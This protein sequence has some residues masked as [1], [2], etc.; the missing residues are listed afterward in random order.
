MGYLD[1]LDGILRGG[2]HGL[3]ESFAAAQAAWIECRELPD[4][5]FAGRRGGNADVYY[6]DFAL[7]ALDLVAGETPIFATTARHL[8]WTARSPADV[9]A[10][11]SLLSC[12]RTLRRHDLSVRCDRR[13]VERA[14]G[15]QALPGGA[16]GPPEV[17]SAS[18]YQTFLAVL[19]LQMLG[20]DAPSEETCA[21]MAAL[22]RDSGGFAER[23]DGDRA[24][25]NAT[26]A[27]VAVLLM[28]NA[29]AQIDLPA[30]A[31]FIIDRQA[32]DGGL[33]AHADATGGDLLS[34]F[35]GLLTL[36][37]IGAPSELDLPA[38][39]RFVRGAAH[40]GGG[41]GALPG[42]PQADVEYTF[43]GIATFGLLRSLVEGAG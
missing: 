32:P 14:I 33:C 22:Q 8:Q 19:C 20:Q 13:S 30:V 6:T 24:Q 10:A 2:A 9:T 15:S 43:Y 41:F 18:A 1:L 35:T 34:T 25:T 28:G 23:A 21:E 38:L 17:L 40:A 29:L 42:D 39:G 5:G 27:A 4:G 11:F 37:L 36:A 26:S 3:G 16:F 7:R 31:R 12:A